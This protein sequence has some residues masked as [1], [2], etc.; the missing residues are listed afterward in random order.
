MQNRSTRSHQ[1]SWCKSL[2]NQ[3]ANQQLSDHTSSQP[4][5]FQIGSKSSL[6][7]PRRLI[8]P[9][10]LPRSPVIILTGIPV[11]TLIRAH[12]VHVRSDVV[13]LIIFIRERVL[14]YAAWYSAMRTIHW[15]RRS[16]SRSRFKRGAS[17]SNARCRRL[18]RHG[19]QSLWVW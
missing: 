8:R 2:T 1:N 14:G 4:S 5:I 16:R 11:A 3:R 19:L 13:E 12:V 15:R 9:S 18:A 7:I 10:A 6:P 17:C